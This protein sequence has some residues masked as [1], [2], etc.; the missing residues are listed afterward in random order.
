MISEILSIQELSLPIASLRGFPTIKFIN[1]DSLEESLLSQIGKPL[2][3]KGTGHVILGN[4]MG[5]GIAWE[6][7]SGIAALSPK[8]ACSAPC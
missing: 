6:E 3:L 2:F 4:G 8:F 5:D 1:T 7:H